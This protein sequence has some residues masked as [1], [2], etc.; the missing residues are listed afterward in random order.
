MN[1]YSEGLKDTELKLDEQGFLSVQV[2]MFAFI[3]AAP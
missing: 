1:P 2:Q 3:V